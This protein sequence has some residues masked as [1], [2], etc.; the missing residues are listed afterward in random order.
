MNKNEPT[1]K[2]ENE[3]KKVN[4]DKKLK[5]YLS[6]LNKLEAGVFLQKLLDEKGKTVKYISD[7]GNV[8]ESL[9]YKFISGE[10]GMGREKMLIIACSIGLSVEETNKLLKMS[11]HNKLYA[12]DK[13][14][15]LLIYA[16]E[17]KKSV[18][19]IIELLEENGL[20][21]ELLPE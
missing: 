4:D 10:R 5:E 6:K 17:N 9:I 15:S 7:H 19:E 1:D 2:F 20:K 13:R 16:L 3:L 11:G 18:E 14:D 8:S 21:L 12:K